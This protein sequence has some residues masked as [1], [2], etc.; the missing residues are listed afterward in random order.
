M[1]SKSHKRTR[2]KGTEAAGPSPPKSSLF[3][4]LVVFVI[5]ELSL[6]GLDSYYVVAQGDTA[7]D[8]WFDFLIVSAIIVFLV[9]LAY[10]VVRRMLVRV[11]R[12]E[13]RFHELS[14]SLPEAVFEADQTGILLY[15]NKVGLNWFGYDAGEVASGTLNVLDV[16]S[17]Q[18][19]QTAA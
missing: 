7:A 4:F 5:A 6:I 1:S 9:L 8:F 15:A 19:R 12:S 18:D 14:D 16:V 2:E 13:R 3:L 17:E 10:F 11:I